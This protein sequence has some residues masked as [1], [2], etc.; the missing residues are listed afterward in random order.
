MSAIQPM[1]LKRRTIPR[2]LCRETLIIETS[3]NLYLLL[4]AACMRNRALSS[5][6][7]LARGH[8]SRPSR[9]SRADGVPSFA[10][11]TTWF[12]VCWGSS[13][14]C[15]SLSRLIQ[16]QLTLRLSVRDSQTLS[17]FYQLLATNVSG[18]QRSCDELD[19]DRACAQGS[20]A[21]W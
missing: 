12:K 8:P 17:P 21:L 6:F 16:P 10:Y 7:V 14:Q 20:G 13:Q 9:P 5:S 19:R 1:R 4:H 11:T 15:Q 3:L 18:V 2:T